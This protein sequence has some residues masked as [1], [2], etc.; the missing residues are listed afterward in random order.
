MS[1][2]ILDTINKCSRQSL[3]VCEL[4]KVFPEPIGTES[5]NGTIYHVCC[6]EDC[7]Y[8]LKVI[9]HGEDLTEYHIQHE[10]SMQKKFH[11]FGLAPKIVEA[12]S[13]DNKSYIIMEKMDKDLLSVMQMLT[14]A[15]ENA[16]ENIPVVFLDLAARMLIAKAVQLVDKAHIS[17][18]VHGDSHLPNF[19]LNLSPA[20][21]IILQ[22]FNECLVRSKDHA[23][24]ILSQIVK[25]ETY[26]AKDAMYLAI[27]SWQ[28]NRNPTYFT[29][30]R[31][32]NQ[33][34]E[35]SLA[36]YEL[37]NDAGPTIWKFLSTPKQ[38][39]KFLNVQSMK[40]IDFGLTQEIRTH[41][42]LISQDW[43]KLGAWAS[44]FESFPSIKTVLHTF[45]LV[46][47]LE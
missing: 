22:D 25:K 44:R 1:E 37:F 20:L 39:A 5:F 13:C 6:K 47:S 18:Y 46:G 2:S 26:D 33:I 23:K 19:M 8:V 11:E 42:E 17:G 29:R 41:P 35:L 9:S 36:L 3:G 43:R 38:L 4:S 32:S 45:T 14:S 28:F 31:V 27:L 12:F 24:E 40:M 34:K 16:A 7:S 15:A 30:T 10:V 21:P